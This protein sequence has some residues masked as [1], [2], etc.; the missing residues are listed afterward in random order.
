MAEIHSLMRRI[1]SA[2]KFT[3]SPGSIAFSPNPARGF[4]F[5][6]TLYEWHIKQV[7]KGSEVC[8]RSPEKSRAVALAEKEISRK[9]PYPKSGHSL[10]KGELAIYA[11]DFKARFVE[12]GVC[13]ER[14]RTGF[15][16]VERTR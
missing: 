3:K 15:A 13:R 2:Y 10:S 9:R 8:R 11:A 12:T 14:S 4:T 5:P 16:V 1:P 7:T 6:V